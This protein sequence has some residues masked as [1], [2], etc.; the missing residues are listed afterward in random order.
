VSDFGRAAEAWIKNNV[1]LPIQTC[2]S[3]R[4][5]EELPHAVCFSGR[6]YVVVR[7][8]LLEHQPHG[9]DVFF[10]VTPVAAGVKVAK[11]QLVLYAG[12]DSGHGH[13]DFSGDE[14]FA[15]PWRFMIEQDAVAGVKP[16]CFPV[17]HGGPISM[18]LCA[19]I[20]TARVKRG[21]FT[22]R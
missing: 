11:A 1:F 22:L 18:H 4:D 14:G 8:F 12:K 5:L 19:R 7:F 20:R 15:A 17:I 6:N 3:E 21:R 10:R 2:V 13:C 16:V 9:F